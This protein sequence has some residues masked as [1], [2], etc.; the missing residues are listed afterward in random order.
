[1]S[2]FIKKHIKRIKVRL[3]SDNKLI[4][5][6]NLSL[7]IVILILSLNLFNIE[8][9]STGKAVEDYGEMLCIVNY[10]DNFNVWEDIDGC[11]L[12]VRKQLNC[13]KEKGYYTDKVLDWKCGT[14]NLNYWLNN[15]AYSYCKEQVIW[16]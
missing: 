11:C 2:G 8:I 9:S 16:K 5:T 10:E 1:M 13:V 4:I 12:E 14:G 3:R 6:L 15:D 7:L